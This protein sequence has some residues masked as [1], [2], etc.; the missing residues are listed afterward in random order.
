[1]KKK[2]KKV[3]KKATKKPVKKKVKK[4]VK[5]KKTTKK[6]AKKGLKKAKKSIGLNRKP[7][8][9]Y[10]LRAI[11]NEEPLGNGEPMLEEAVV[12]LSAEEQVRKAKEEAE[13]KALERDVRIII[14]DATTIEGSPSGV[15]SFII[16]LR[17]ALIE[18]KEGE[19]TL[20]SLMGDISSIMG[21]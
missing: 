2:A 19:V 3:V 11:T 16:N 20:G 1:M 13:K 14:S 7:V 9:R 17:K 8:P 5:K 15:A 12:I 18:D 10:L 4:A 6:S 21:D